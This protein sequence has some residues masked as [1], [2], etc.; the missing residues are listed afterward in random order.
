MESHDVRGAHPEHAPHHPAEHRHGIGPV[1]TSYRL[2]I[3]T[4]LWVIVGLLFLG[5]GIW[6]VLT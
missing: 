6:W 2:V 5:F 3:R 1:D 4:V